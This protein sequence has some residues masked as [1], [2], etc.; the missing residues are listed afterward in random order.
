MKLVLKG[1]YT[2]VD[3]LTVGVLPE[4]AV[5]FKEP[6]SMAD[7]NKSAAYFL[8]PV[9]VILIT[10]YLLKHGLTLSYK[11]MFT[12]GY[13]IGFVLAILCIFPHELL[14]GICFPKDAEVELWWSPKNF[15]VFVHSVAPI[16]KARFIFLSLLPSLLFGI[17]PLSI[18]LFVPSVNTLLASAL[19]GFGMVSLLFGVGDFLNVYNAF[20]Q[21][22]KG[23]LTQLS[24]F[25][26]YWFYPE[27]TMGSFK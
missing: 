8:L 15:M 25:H 14:H 11:D 12:G 21:V 17:L 3:Q 4:N 7:L 5:K 20:N 23:A 19:W 9:L 10:F 27:E 24:G 6:E 13:L 18:W 2:S 22:P 16:S 26:S 1:E